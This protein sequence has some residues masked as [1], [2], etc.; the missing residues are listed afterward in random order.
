MSETKT[1]HIGDVLSI[2]TGRLVP[3]NHIGGV[4]EILNWVT[5]DNLMTHQLPRAAREAEPFLREWFP[6]LADVTAPEFSGKDEVLEWLDSMVAEHGETRE[7]PRLATQ[8]HTR[9]DPISEIK[10]IRPDMP[11]IAIGGTDD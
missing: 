7:V 3:P 10:M 4:Y 5:D 2:T 6:D 8:D 1:F 11:I 9:I